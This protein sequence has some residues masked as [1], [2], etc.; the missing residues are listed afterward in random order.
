MQ[1]FDSKMS[2]LNVAKGDNLGDNAKNDV[3]DQEN[4]RE[5]EKK[6][7][8]EVCNKA[9]KSKQLLGVHIRHIHKPAEEVRVHKCDKCK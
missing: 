2:M 8:C 3:E 7:V 5:P 4:E 9:Y 1:S 6:F